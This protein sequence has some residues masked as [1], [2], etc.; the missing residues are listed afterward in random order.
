MRGSILLHRQPSYYVGKHH[1]LGMIRNDCIYIFS[2]IS[3]SG[4][5]DVNWTLTEVRRLLAALLAHVVGVGGPHVRGLGVGPD[6]VALRRV[7][8]LLLR[9]DPVDFS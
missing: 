7:A 9:Y 1:C 2:R 3:L 8:H 6:H 4:S 5:D